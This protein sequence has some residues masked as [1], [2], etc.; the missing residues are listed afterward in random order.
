[1]SSTVAPVRTRRPSPPAPRP[2]ADAEPAVSAGRQWPLLV[3]AFAGGIVA[4]AGIYWDLGWHYDLGRDTPLAPPHL[5]IILGS[6][7]VTFPLL[8]LAVL[9]DRA[10][11]AGRRVA[12][13]LR[14]SGGLTWSPLVA[15]AIAGSVVPPVAL[16]L[17]EVWHRI[18]GLDTSLWSPTHLLAILS[19]PLSFLSIAAIAAADLNR[20]DRGRLQP[21]LRDWRGA[22]RADALLVAGAGLVAVTLFVPWAEFDFDLPQWDLALAAPLLAAFTGFPA[23]LAIEAV[24]RRWSAA[25][26]LGL[27]TLVRLA[28]TGFVLAAG[29][30]HPDIVLAVL[31]ALALDALVIARGA[32]LRGR[33]LGL[34]LLAWGPLVIGTEAVRLLAIGQEKWLAG[35]WPWSWLAAIA[36]GAAAGALGVAAGRCLRPAPREP[37]RRAAV[38][39]AAAAVLGCVAFALPALVPAGAVAEPRGREVVNAQMRITPAEPRPGEPVTVRVSGFDRVRYV[40]QG[41]PASEQVRRSSDP[42]PFLESRGRRPELISYYGGDWLRIPLRRA[43]PEAFEARLRFPGEGVWRTGPAFFQGDRRFI[44]RIRLQVRDEGRAQAPRV[45]DLELAEEAAPTDAPQLL[46]PIAFG[47]L[48]LIFAGAVFLTVVQLRIVRRDGIEPASSQA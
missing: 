45:F 33:T 29:R 15:I 24:G 11:R 16:S 26:A 12:L 20:S 17:D 43:G 32:S 44:E 2:A 7:L 1:V 35:L 27:F 42:A 34:A 3:C 22:G 8:V 39:A 47:L 10:A 37:A 13:P 4:A 36:A 9:V 48:G 21:R 46:K 6:S 31:P 14:R 18:F 5:L 38:P 40:T 25:L 30:M 19:G 41:F 28:T 23:F